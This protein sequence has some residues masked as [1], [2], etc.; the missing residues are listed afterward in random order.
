MKYLSAFLLV[1]FCSCTVM[2]RCD[3]DAYVLDAP[4]D[5][6]KS[7]IEIK[8]KYCIG[9]TI[10]KPDLGNETLLKGNVVD[11]NTGQGLSAIINIDQAKNLG[12]QSDSDGYFEIVVLAGNYQLEVVQIGKPRLKTEKLIFKESTV[13]EINFFLGESKIE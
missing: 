6:S 11:R 13:V 8:G 5:L 4:K 10:E 2:R 9:E 3:K 1:S 12:T 7:R